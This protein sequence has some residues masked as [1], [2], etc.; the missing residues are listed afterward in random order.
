MNYIIPLNFGKQEFCDTSNLEGLM[1]TYLQK[2][3]HATGGEE[4]LHHKGF[5]V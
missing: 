1:K 5:V 2:N 3:Y 4:T